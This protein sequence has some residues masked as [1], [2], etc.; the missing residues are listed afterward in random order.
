MENGD[1]CDTGSS[2]LFKINILLLSGTEE[3][4]VYLSKYS[5]SG[6]K[7]KSKRAGFD[8]ESFCF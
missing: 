4:Q 6:S 7:L 1:S 3:N 2:G 8:F 5:F